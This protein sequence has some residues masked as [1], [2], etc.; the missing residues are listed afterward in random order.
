MPSFHDID[1]SHSL[2]ALRSGEIVTLAEAK[3]HLRVDDNSEETNNYIQSLIKVAR[4][5]TEKYCARSFVQQERVLRLDRFPSGNSPIYIPRGA[6]LSIEEFEYIDCDA[7]SNYLD[8]D[9]FVLDG[10]HLPARVV[11]AHGKCWPQSADIPGAVRIRFFSG[12]SGTGA[13][14]DIDIATNV[15]A[16]LKHAQLLLI[17]HF[18]D[19]RAPLNIG[20]I[21]NN[22]PWSVDALLSDFRVDGV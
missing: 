6:V 15:P 5:A 19:Q 18:Y 12:Y 10:D 17:Q 20:N 16:D 13:A 7:Q 2:I 8:A 3:N 11:P 14:P 21:V 22:L 9:D 1:R 4:A